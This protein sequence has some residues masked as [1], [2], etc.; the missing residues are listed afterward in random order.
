MNRTFIRCGAPAA[1]ALSLSLVLATPAAAA[2]DDPDYRLV[3]KS[4]P[5]AKLKEF[6]VKGHVGKIRVNATASDEI[7]LRLE[8]RAKSYSGWLFGR[9]RGDPHAAQLDADVHGEALSLNLD[10]KGDRDGLEE[11]WTLDVP[12]RLAAQIE[13]AV[14]DMDVRG[15]RG[16][17]KLSVNVGDIEADVPEGS[18]TAKTNVGDIT[19]TS[20]TDSF[21]AVDLSA[22]VGDTHLTQRGHR[23]RYRK[24]PGAGN[25]ITLDGPGRDRIR[26]ETNVGD[27]TLTLRAAS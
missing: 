18:I 2:S 25:H 27:A 6:S 20:A 9:R 26:L 12:A 16:G 10:Y 4:F 3:T 5:A 13:L 7:R 19:V 11:T 23:V 15:L 22:N 17:L 8:L 14:G 1:L 21:G 24:P